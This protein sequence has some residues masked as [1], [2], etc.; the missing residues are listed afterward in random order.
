MISTFISSSGREYARGAV[1]K[2]NTKRPKLSLCVAYCENQP[3]V[4][5]ST[6]ATIFQL[7]QKLKYEFESTRFRHHIDANDDEMVLVYEW[8]KDD[9]LQL[10]TKHPNITLTSRKW[11]LREIG[12]ALK[13]MHAKE[14][15]DIDVKPDNVFVN[16]RLDGQGLV[17]IEKVAIGNVM[18]SSPEQLTG[19]GIAKPSDVFAFGLIL[20]TLGLSPPGL[21]THINDEVWIATMEEYSK[22]C[23]MDFPDLDACTKEFIS[24]MTEHDPA[25]RATMEELMADPWWSK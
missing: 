14:W 8:Y 11:T 19:Q 17:A 7:L 22:A 6:S 15:V 10:I 23:E 2:P 21:L 18:W 4:L 3:F 20:H 24:R 5:K 25:K 13:D 12:E 16:W 1:L 9:L